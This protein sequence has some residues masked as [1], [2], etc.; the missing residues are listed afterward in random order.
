MFQAFQNAKNTHQWLHPLHPLPTGTNVERIQ[1]R[2]QR[3][4]N[5][6]KQLWLPLAQASCPQIW[7]LVVTLH[8]CPRDTAHDESDSC[9]MEQVHRE[10]LA[11]ELLCVPSAE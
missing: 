1:L 4:T 10:R 5:P 9:G 8:L 2:S 11:P 7:Q 6:P 3:R